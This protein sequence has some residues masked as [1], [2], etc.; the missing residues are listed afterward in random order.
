MLK[1]ENVLQAVLLA[2]SFKVFFRPLTLDS[3]KFTQKHRVRL[4]VRGRD[5]YRP[6]R[7]MVL[8]KGFFRRQFLDRPRVRRGERVRGA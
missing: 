4:R 1:R 6:K 2:D 5:R 7:R 8:C 3:P